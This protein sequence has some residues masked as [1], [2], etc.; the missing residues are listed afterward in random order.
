MQPDALR[1]GADWLNAHKT[2]WDRPDGPACPPRRPT[3]KDPDM[4]TDTGHFELT[5]TFPLTPDRLW[6]VLTDAEMREAHGTCTG[7]RDGS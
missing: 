6:H 1:A 7:R 2:M 3:G 4:T 5:R